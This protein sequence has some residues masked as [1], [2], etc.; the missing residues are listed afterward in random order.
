M[1]DKVKYNSLNKNDD[2]GKRNCLNIRVLKAKLWSLSFDQAAID[3]CTQ[4]G[5]PDEI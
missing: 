5:G 1:K 4:D 2:T 3:D